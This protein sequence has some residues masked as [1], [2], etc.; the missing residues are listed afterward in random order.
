MSA[1]AT[2]SPRL[3][4]LLLHGPATTGLPSIL[5]TAE[6]IQSTA[7]HTARNSLAARH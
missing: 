4:L 2:Q 6:V 3:L 1:R 7:I 5:L